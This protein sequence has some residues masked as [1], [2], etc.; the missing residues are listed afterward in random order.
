MFPKGHIVYRGD[1]SFNPAKAHGYQPQFFTP[2]QDVAKSQY[3]ELVLKF[4]STREIKLLRLDKNAE[5]FHDW[6]KNTA[7][8]ADSDKQIL[9]KNFGYP[10][11]SPVNSS[12]NNQF[13]PRVS[14]GEKDRKMLQMI[15][16]YAKETG[17]EIDGYY[18]S[19]MSN[20]ALG[21]LKN[22]TGKA[23]LFHAELAVFNRDAFDAPEMAGSFTA[24]Q[25]ES[26]NMA[27]N[28][29][30]RANE[31]KAA[32]AEK[33]NNRRKTISESRNPDETTAIAKRQR[34]FSI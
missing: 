21:G 32:R 8:F 27:A 1:N 31:D 4:T 18:N 15:E 23:P 11:N 16:A 2:E 12:P 10:K 14:E 25:I 20:G 6:L 17:Q 29:I 30:R 22:E 19:A 28:L 7:H 34:L 13:R 24:D 26:M 5:G 3:G 33:I 9:H